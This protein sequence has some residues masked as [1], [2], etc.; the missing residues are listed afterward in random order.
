MVKDLDRQIQKAQA[1]FDEIIK[2]M[3]KTYHESAKPTVEFFQSWYNEQAREVVINNK[4]SI[5]KKIGEQKVSRLKQEIQKLQNN[6]EDTV[7]EFLQHRNLWWHTQ[8]ADPQ[9]ISTGNPPRDV[10]EALSLIAG[11]IAVVF[12]KFGYISLR[13]EDR[14]WVK[15]DP[16]SEFERPILLHV[17]SSWKPLA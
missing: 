5:T 15:G 12:D 14:N 8:Y 13:G 6:T 2:E 9:Y 7:S 10:N 3:S 1:D 11:K 4:P 17:S 16:N